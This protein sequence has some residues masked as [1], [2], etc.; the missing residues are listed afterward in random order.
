MLSVAVQRMSIVIGQP[1]I[2]T[3]ED[4][5]VRG[6]RPPPRRS[7]GRPPPDGRSRHLR[8]PATGCRAFAALLHDRPRART[9]PRTSR[10][11]SHGSRRRSS[12]FTEKR[13]PARPRRT[14]HPRQLQSSRPSVGAGSDPRC[15][16]PNQPPSPTPIL[17]ALCGSGLR[18]RCPHRTSHPRQPHSSRPSV[19]ADS[20][21]R[22]PRRTNHPRQTQSSRPSVGAGS[23]PR[24]RPP[25]RPSA[26]T[27]TILAICGSGLRPAMPA[28]TD[29][30][31]TPRPSSPLCGSGLRPA[32]PHP[33]SSLP[34]PT[35]LAPLWERAPTRDAP[36]ETDPLAETQ[37]SRP[38]VGAGSDPRCPRDV[39]RT[40]Q[41]EPRPLRQPRLHRLGRRLP[42]ASSPDACR[43]AWRRRDRERL[44]HAVHHGRAA[45]CDG[46]AR[47]RRQPHGNLP[48]YAGELFRRPRWSRSRGHAC[49]PD[50]SVIVT[51][52]PN[53][54]PRGSC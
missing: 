17:S 24:C 47:A 22:C 9:P 18:P 33:T 35:I 14:N 4:E 51:N 6:Y 46:V 43:L 41:G 29:P 23:D 38:S 39:I 19:G 5:N 49:P 53:P 45:R 54:T 15:P 10:R 32:M 21:P 13:Y 52:S 3:G 11:A 20:D 7:P 37:S 26:H 2:A 8:T 27:P 36:A 31:P 16:R 12:P 40:Y 50:L 44:T 1:I 25:N 42:R 28:P 48:E 30:S 34:T